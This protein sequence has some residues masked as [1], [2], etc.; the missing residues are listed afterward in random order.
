MKKII[1]GIFFP[2]IT[3]ISGVSNAQ[4]IDAAFCKQIEGVSYT[5]AL[6][7]DGRATSTNKIYAKGIPPCGEDPAYPLYTVGTYKITEPNLLEV[8]FPGYMH[9]AGT[10]EPD[11]NSPTYIELYDTDRLFTT[12]YKKVGN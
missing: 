8:T 6:H 7:S 9:G 3:L 1:L 2:L 11:A 12:I 4:T 10:I 5:I